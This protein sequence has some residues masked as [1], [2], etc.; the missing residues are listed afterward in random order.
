MKVKPVKNTKEFLDIIDGKSNNYYSKVS[1]FAYYPYTYRDNRDE[2]NENKAKVAE[3]SEND[4]YDNGKYSNKFLDNIKIGDYAF[5]GLN[6]ANHDQKNNKK[7][8]ISFQTMHESNNSKSKDFYIA[9][10]LRDAPDGG[11]ASG[12]FMFDII[13]HT[14]ATNLP[15]IGSVITKIKHKPDNEFQLP[16]EPFNL[17]NIEECNIEYG[18]LSYL[19]VSQNK[20]VTLKDKYDALKLLSKT[21]NTINVK[22]IDKDDNEFDNKVK[23]IIHNNENTLK[24]LKKQSIYELTDHIMTNDLPVFVYLMRLLRPKKLLCF[25]ENT[26]KLVDALLDQTNLKCKLGIHAEKLIHYSNSSSD[27]EKSDR[28]NNSL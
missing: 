20:K 18:S 14:I 24:Q 5:V 13:S 15:M 21:N 9:R 25:G 16:D 10:M 8:D 6:A 28:L 1:S 27:K 19:I 26:Y 2:Y 12:S 23:S 17:N 11:K 7:Y 4:I 22:N 3:L